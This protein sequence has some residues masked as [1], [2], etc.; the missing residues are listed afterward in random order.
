VALHQDRPHRGAL[1]VVVLAA[2]AARG[3]GGLEETAVA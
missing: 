2:R 1:L 3:G